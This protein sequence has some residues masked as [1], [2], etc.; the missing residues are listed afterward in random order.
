MKWKTR[1]TV[2]SVLAILGAAFY[3]YLLH[4]TTD[5]KNAD[6]WHVAFSYQ[7]FH[8]RVCLGRVESLTYR[9]APIGIP[10]WRWVSSFETPCMIIKTPVGEYCAFEKSKFWGAMH[11]PFTVKDIEETPTPTEIAQ[12]WYDATGGQPREYSGGPFVRKAETPAHWCLLA[13][14]DVARW[15]APERI[16]QL[17]W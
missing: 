4:R 11:L 17:A 16:F 1:H 6:G 10:S 7:P 12:G 5:V 2:G 14:G 9:D 8:C 13:T 3:V 15:V